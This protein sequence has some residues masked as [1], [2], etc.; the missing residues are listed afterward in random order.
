V[1]AQKDPYSQTVKVNKA[2]MSLR[3]KEIEDLKNT[4]V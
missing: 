2:T 1:I 4:G 3:K